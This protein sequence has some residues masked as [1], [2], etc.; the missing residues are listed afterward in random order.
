MKTRFTLLDSNTIETF[1]SSK[2]DSADVD[3]LAQL[4]ANP[5]WNGISIFLWES[6]T[7]MTKT[8]TMPEVRTFAHDCQP[9]R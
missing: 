3:A 8:A 5:N 7:V 9:Q 4:F 2:L 1:A 6:R